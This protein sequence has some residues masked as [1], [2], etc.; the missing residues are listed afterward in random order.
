MPQPPLRLLGP[1]NQEPER[2]VVQRRLQQRRKTGEKNGVGKK[3]QNKQKKII[4]KTPIRSGALRD[5]E[6]K[7]LRG[8]KKDGDE[9]MRMDAGTAVGD[10]LFSFLF[11]VFCR[12]YE[13]LSPPP[14]A[15]R[16]VSLSPVLLRAL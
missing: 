9:R 14:L 8:E 1:P 5:N 15:P 13:A 10:R 16:C 6:P 12:V 7:T 4:T 11:V 3:T 2:R